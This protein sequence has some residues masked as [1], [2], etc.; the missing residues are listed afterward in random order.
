[1]CLRRV[2]AN[3]FASANGYLADQFLQDTCNKRT[4]SWGGSIENRCRF[5]LEVTKALAAE[6]GSSRT[7]VRLSPWSDFNGMLMDDPVPTFTHLVSELRKM[8]IGF[9]DLIEARIRGNDDCDV[10]A[11]K[12]VSWLVKL[13]DNTSPVLLNGG[14]TAESAREVVDEKYAG[15]EVAIILVDT[16]SAI[17][18]SCTG[19]KNPSL[20]STTA[21]PFT[22]RSSSKVTRIGRSATVS[23]LK[24]GEQLCCLL[25]VA[26]TTSLLA[27]P[28][29]PSPLSTPTK[30]TSRRLFA[31]RQYLAHRSRNVNGACKVRELYPSQH[32]R[33]G[34]IR[35]GSKRD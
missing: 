33:L 15:Y 25:A 24:R 13:W 21:R 1:M 22:R 8:K 3:L 35:R 16:L 5:H 32:H 4:D 29:T 27:P 34:S 23:L 18:I 20:P 12:D 14:F 30:R 17:R 28:S 31:P 19:S 9:L 11:D 7:A 26:V 10:N 6:V 2:C